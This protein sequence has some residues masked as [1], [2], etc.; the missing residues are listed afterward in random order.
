MKRSHNGGEF[1]STDFNKL[2][3]DEGIFHQF[4][5]SYA[6]SQ[7]AKME[8]KHKD[9]HDIERAPKFI[10]KFQLNTKVNVF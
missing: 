3:N 5:C 6:S 8:R 10:Q 9:H 2:L 4:S 1:T 7:N